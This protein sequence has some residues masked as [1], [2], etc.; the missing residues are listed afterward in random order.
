MSDQHRLAAFGAVCAFALMPLGQAIAQEVPLLPPDAKAGQCYTRVFVPA[1]YET[2]EQRLVAVEGT[3]AGER[4]ARG[5]SPRRGP[6]QDKN[7]NLRGL[8]TARGVA[9]GPIFRM[10]KPVDLKQIEYQPKLEAAEEHSDAEPHD[11]ALT[12][13]AEGPVEAAT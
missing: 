10:D 13:D 7:V 2:K 6:R 5:G 3:D 8:A 12:S 11:P 1:A 4:R 9:I